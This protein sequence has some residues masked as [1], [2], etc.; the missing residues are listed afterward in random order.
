MEF[1]VEDLAPCRKKVTVTVPAERV[2]KEV[3]GQYAEVNKQVS[4]P[5]FRPGKA[6]RKLLE[7][8]FGTHIHGEVKQKIVE[9]AYKQLI[10]EKRIAPLTQP[11]VN[12]DAQ[13][14][15]PAKAFEFAFEVTTRPDFEL[16]TW[17]GLEVKVPAGSVTDADIDSGVERLR[18]QE[19]SLV[20]SEGG[21][22]ADD[23]VVFDWKATEGDAVLHAEDSVYYRLGQ[24]VLDGIAIDGLEAKI[25]GA[26]AGDAFV[27]KGRA[28]P[29]DV[30]PAIAGKEF[31]IRLDVK[32]IKRFKPA[33][34]D[35]EFLKRHDFDDVE[36]LRLDV[37][38]KLHRLRD[39]ERDRLAEERLLDG[40]VASVTF[41]LPAEIVDGSV[42][43]WTERQR[44]EA[45]SEGRDADETARKLTAEKD[46]MRAKV[47][48][49]LRRH[50]VL[51]KICEAE[52]LTV[53]EQELV[54]AVE[55]I[56]RDN[57]RSASEV[58]EHFREQPDRLAEL[59]AHLKHE[60][61]REAIRKAAIL[62]DETTP[63]AAA[64]KT[65][66]KA[67]K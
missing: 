64:A 62:V 59:R 49:D 9:A 15:D 53:S 45:A 29:D 30:R 44:A 23:V 66:P 18:L 33:D 22:A 54:G 3:D 21:A 52:N 5:G 41:D 8:K 26:K 1:R 51:E 57:G 19:G 55:Q 67:S 58:I 27:L 16:P 48:S 14:L 7:S 43:D 20:P 42:A 37:S 31:T 65:P 28:A 50:F 32:E 61:A 12:V 13:A 38:K 2:R 11:E 35:A 63:P 10:D 56:G 46:Q 34:L 25:L 17:K 4:L 60:K 47:E 36:E 39:R 40:L 24:G 6:P